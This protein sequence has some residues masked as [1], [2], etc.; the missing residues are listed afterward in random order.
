M[1]RAN[2]WRSCAD[3]PSEGGSTILIS[4]LLGEVLTTAD[5]IVV[6]RDGVVVKADVADTYTRASLVAAMGHIPEAAQERAASGL[7]R[8]DTMATRVTALPRAGDVVGLIAHEGE[9]V[10]LAGL[11][12]QG[13]T[14]MLLRVFDGARGDAEVTG[15]V[16]VI[17]G[18]R[19]KR[20]HLPVVVDRQERLH[21]FAV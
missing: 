20:R 6:M 16:A 11:A 5:R 21:R 3:S 7:A 13:Q 17:A 4:H 10:G 12:G 1:S 9:V 19:Q 2:C 18:D 14:Q 8:S 15:T